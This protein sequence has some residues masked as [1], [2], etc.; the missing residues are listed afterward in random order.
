MFLFIGRRRATP[1]VVYSPTPQAKMWGRICIEVVIQ[2]TTLT[3][4]ITITKHRQSITYKILNVLTSNEKAD[5]KMHC[6]PIWTSKFWIKYILILT[7]GAS[8]SRII[9]LGAFF[10]KCL[11]F[12]SSFRIIKELKFGHLF[13]VLKVYIYHLCSQ[14][15]LKFKRRSCI[16]P[17][18]IF[19]ARNSQ[20]NQGVF[21]CKYLSWIFYWSYASYCMYFWTFYIV[22]ILTYFVFTMTSNHVNFVLRF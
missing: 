2:I 3:L 1:G 19:S 22:Y 12:L 5:K 17:V 6:N 11:N 15:S 8:Y 4:P 16:R 18:F 20:A 21:L 7:N 14:R 10:L 13:H 9:Q